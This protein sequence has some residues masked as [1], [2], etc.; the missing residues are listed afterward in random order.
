MLS[1]TILTKKFINNQEEK[2]RM[3]PKLGFTTLERLM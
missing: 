3:L 2:D 1:Q